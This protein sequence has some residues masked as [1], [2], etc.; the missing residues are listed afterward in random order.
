MDTPDVRTSSPGLHKVLE[1]SDFIFAILF[2]VEC[3]LNIVAFGFYPESDTAYLRDDWN[4]IDFVVAIVALGST[5]LDFLRPFRAVRTVR[6]IVRLGGPRRMAL[7]VMGTLREVGD[8]VLLLLSFMVVWAIL[9]VQLF[10]GTFN[11]C[12]DPTVI[13]KAQCTGWYNA[14]SVT[15]YGVVRQ[16]AQRDWVPSRRQT[17]DNIGEALLSLF[18]VLIGDGWASI[19]WAAV[20]VRGYEQSTDFNRQPWNAIYFVIFIVI[21]QF[22]TVNIFVS[23]LI[24]AVL[25]RRRQQHDEVVM[26]HMKAKMSEEHFVHARVCAFEWLQGEKRLREQRPPPLQTRP[27]DAV[28]SLCY[29]IAT[30][31]WGPLRMRLTAESA[32]RSRRSAHARKLR[33]EQRPA[34]TESSVWSDSEARFVDLPD[35]LRGASYMYGPSSVR[36]G[37][38]F[39]LELSRPARVVVLCDAESAEAQEQHCAT[40]QATENGFIE[41]LIEDGWR[42][43]LAGVYHAMPHSQEVTRM[44]CLSTTAGTRFG[45]LPPQVRLPMTEAERTLMCV[46]AVPVPQRN[47]FELCITLVIVL[48]VIV[49]S[50]THAGETDRWIRART[51]ANYIFVAI[52]VLE[53]IIKVLGLGWS[54]YWYS[55]MNR[56]DFAIV[57]VSL[58]RFAVAFPGG[59]A[60]LRLFRVAR[61][62]RLIRT[63]RGLNMM[64][65]TLTTSLPQLGNVSWVLCIVVFIFAAIG[66]DLFGH[67]QTSQGM[68]EFSNFKTVYH[69]YVTLMQVTTTEGWA[70][71]MHTLISAGVS[72]W[73]C[74][75]YFMT[76]L[77]MCGILLVN[78]FVAVVV[79]SY[80]EAMVQ[81]SAAQYLDGHFAPFIARWQ[82][83]DRHGAGYLPADTVLGL[84]RQ[85]ARAGGAAWSYNLVELWAYQQSRG[86]LGATE[87]Q[88]MLRGLAPLCV[89]VTREG[90]VPFGDLVALLALRLYQLPLWVAA[91]LTRRGRNP[92]RSDW[93]SL[94]H[95]HALRK[96]QR[97]QRRGRMV[98]RFAPVPMLWL[99]GVFRR[100]LHAER[101]RHTV[102]AAARAAR[103]DAE[104]SD[105]GGPGPRDAQGE[106][107]RELNRLGLMEVD[108][109]VS[110]S[111]AP[112]PQD[113]R[114]AGG[115]PFEPP[116]SSV[117]TLP[118]TASGCGGTPASRCEGQ[119]SPFMPPQAASDTPSEF[120]SGDESH[121]EE[122]PAAP[123][124]AVI[125][126]NPFEAESSGSGDGGAASALLSHGAN[127]G[128]NGAG[129]S[130]AGGVMPAPRPLPQ[131]ADLLRRAPPPP[132]ELEP[133]VE[134]G[135]REAPAELL[136]DGCLL[137]LS[138]AP[139][140]APRRPSSVSTDAPAPRHPGDAEGAAESPELLCV[141][142][143]PSAPPCSHPGDPAPPPAPPAASG[144]AAPTPAPHANGSLGPGELSGGGSYGTASAGEAA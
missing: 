20:D 122:E 44:R 7:M 66:V 105:G 112:P 82:E 111:S 61:L 51:V 11:L 136:A 81:V 124:F 99:P 53:C 130:E 120:W 28:R 97:W 92:L 52:Y 87:F 58:L 33:Y 5:A 95:H 76:F 45:G 3:M 140:G 102:Y 129:S 101:R 108:S 75:I 143:E 2:T 94:H 15:Q 17:F 64:I 31:D 104:G 29:S 25:R 96:L 24:D 38:L 78:V 115:E 91:D 67:V 39:T 1:V 79:E 43:D 16:P 9:G 34:E 74:R 14:S 69:A 27:A 63:A 110:A 48:N 113:P 36:F 60:V 138:A 135:G 137:P 50:F 144:A 93:W 10:K 114:A 19:M 32:L 30:G 55:T 84:L 71:I 127:V 46:V 62:I 85:E 57:C 118:S 109:E 12:N 80:Q 42:E 90:R 18:V 142:A 13:E 26:G 73:S 89:P 126:V 68:S 56:F 88:L 121:E 98:V 116:G 134:C 100:E 40:R 8:T 35:S 107:L 41:A 54:G 49:L 83:A 21:A 47:T 139:A 117:P 72:Q 59:V 119:G 4:K 131:V 125:G 65:T 106:P 22:V 132:A 37:T 70:D 86:C 6:L 77:I 141:G 103:G 133:A 128:R 123:T 23:V